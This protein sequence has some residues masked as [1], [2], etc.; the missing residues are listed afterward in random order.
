VF[1]TL[2]AFLFVTLGVVLGLSVRPDEPR[3]RQ[4]VVVG[5]VNSAD[6]MVLWTG[7]NEVA[8][9]TDAELDEWGS[10]GVDG[11]VCMVGYLHGLG[12][13]S[14]FT[15]EAGASLRRRSYEL[16]RRLRDSDLA[17]RARR[18]GMKLYLGLYASNYYNRA[19]PF[20]AWF[21]DRRWVR[22][23]LPGIE[24]MAAAARRLGFAGLA[25]DQ[26]LYANDDSATWDWNYPGNTRPEQRVRAKVKQRGA[27]LMRAMVRGFPRLELMAYYTKVPGSWEELVQ[28]RGNDLPE[29]FADNIQIDLW[30]GL[31]S[32]RG[33]RAIRWMDAIFY[34]TPQLGEATWEAAL[35]YN[36][37]A[38]YS[39]LSRRFSN[40]AY[41]SS[42]LHLS[43]FSWISSGTTDWER[44]RD[45][46][47]VAEQ[48]E[49]FRKWGTGREFANYAYNGLQVFDYEPYLPAMRA[50]SAPGQ[51][52]SRPP[53]LSI[54]SRSI[55]ARGR[56]LSLRGFA[57]DNLAI[58]AVRW[59]DGARR[60]GIMKLRW[61]VESGDARSGWNSR[62]RW[63]ARDIPLSGRTAT[64]RVTAEDIKGLTTVRTVRV[65]R[66]GTS[67][68]S[69]ESR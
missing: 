35:Q 30:N 2:G 25:L 37:N 20:A 14:R 22:E 55:E 15:G 50:A 57:T 19:T 17:T 67:L 21:D 16:Q 10:R 33:Y 45:P 4:D 3:E 60:S 24:D 43:P 28:E 36:A 1:G 62:T 49:A 41:A 34:K 18:R 58:R 61:I 66:R 40:W 32:V 64:I 29:V 51:V 68:S 26:E 65:R 27:E 54:T 53:G 52:D 48:L 63:T 56:R 11:F 69:G 42:R 39:V 46:G 44:A 9:L 5:E 59:R 8:A 23:V 6:R 38:V 12:G 47:Y 13:S 31:S 7:C